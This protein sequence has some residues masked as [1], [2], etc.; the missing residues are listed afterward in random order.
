MKKN[1]LVI[2]LFLLFCSCGHQAQRSIS[3]AESIS[4]DQSLLNIIGFSTKDLI[5]Q[6]DSEM[7]TSIE[8]L[9]FDHFVSYIR[10]GESGEELVVRRAQDG[11]TIF[12]G[13]VETKDLKA[14][15][16][17]DMK[18]RLLMVKKSGKTSKLKGFSLK[19]VEREPVS[20][21]EVLE[22]MKKKPYDIRNLPTIP[23]TMF[24]FMREKAV[25]FA[26]GRRSTN[27][28]RKGAD[29]RLI[30]EAKPIHPMGIGV[31]GRITIKKT[32]YSGLFA[33]G[34]YPLLGRLSIS[35]GNP[36]KYKER[37]WLD[38]LLNRP[39]KKQERSVA[40]AF[41]VFSSDDADEKV[42]T[43]NAVFQNDL[44]GELFDHYLD[45]VMTN[46]PQLDVT[47]IRK[48]YEVF[49]L[50]G[51]AKGAI[52]NPND[53]KKTFPFINPQLRP[54]HQ[55]AEMGVDDPSQVKTPRWMKIQVV[56]DQSVV[57][58]DD[59]R[60]ELHETIQQKGL[61]YQIFLGDDVDDQGEIIWDEV[62][63][64]D[65][66]NSILSEGVDKNVLFFH[67]GLRS[68][69]TGETIDAPVVPK[70]VRSE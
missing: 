4:C 65:F 52:A 39:A 20:Y 50:I 58:Y 41:K 7:M 25:D 47:K 69:F 44:N 28:L 15:D 67:D 34:S 54:V 29:Y 19:R 61:R 18:G 62:G 22:V 37:T 6:N 64:I 51:V 68:P 13:S 49:T 56:K 59:F 53:R 60:E 5:A 16:Y 36:S 33:G 26:V 21:N 35:Q 46:Q 17:D 63:H 23:L 43:A 70:P 57:K 48:S 14:I 11:E 12:K 2:C 8:P 10:R 66:H 55:L 32:K 1:S 42:V 24:K 45:G 31:E 27:I 40:A 38:K 3:S 30:G 9:F